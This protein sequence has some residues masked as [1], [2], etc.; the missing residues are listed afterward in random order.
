MSSLRPKNGFLG[1]Y[2]GRLRKTK[3]SESENSV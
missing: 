1:S 3:L 2:C